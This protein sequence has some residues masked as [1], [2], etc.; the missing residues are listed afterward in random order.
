MRIGRWVLGLLVLF[1]FVCFLLRGGIVHDPDFG[2]HIQTGNHILKYGIA[3]YDP[4]SYSMPSYPFVDHEWLSNVTWAST[5]NAW[6]SIPLLIVYSLFAVGSLLLQVKIGDKKWASIPFFLAAGTLF[7]FVGIRTQVMTWFFLSVLL[8]VLYQPNVWSKWRFMLP[9]LFLAWA[10]LHGGFGIGLGVLAIF[11][12][13]RLLEEKKAVKETL[14]ILFLCIVA[15]LINPFGFRLWGEFWSQLTDSNL[16]WSITEWYPAI[17]FM[18]MAFWIYFMLSVFLVIRYWKKYTKTEIVL[19]FLLLLAALSSM[20]NIPIWVIAS[21]S[22]TVRGLSLLAHEAAKY[23]YGKE[24]FVIGYRGF[25]IIAIG[26]YLPQLAAFFY[27][28]YALHEYQHT[29]PVQAVAYL[30][31]HLP[32]RQIFSTYD[33]GGYLIWQLPQKKVFIDGRM[34]SWRWDKNIPGE[35]NYAFM[36]YKNVLTEKESF[37]WFAAKYHINTLLVPTSD[38]VPQQTKIFGIRISQNSWL[39]KLFFSWKSFYGVVQQAKKMGWRVVY[40]D[41]T[42]VI[43]E[44]R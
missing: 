23:L 37:A 25:F 43:L 21:F 7:E 38:L 35:S 6:G 14:F 40:Q 27:G 3:Y 29:D 44:Q 16:R 20:R 30:H 22:L 32:T 15:T 10:N 39:K 18:N 33:W 19:Y 8:F 28:A 12:I 5:Y 26:F 42:A 2:W 4:F 13:G 36:E 24:R 41:N 17:Y 31:K 34:P 9:F 1:F 11:L